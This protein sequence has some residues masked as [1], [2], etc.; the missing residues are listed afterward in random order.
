M[1]HATVSVRYNEYHGIKVQWGGCGY[2]LVQE[3]LGRDC[4]LCKSSISAC[5][6]S[7][8]VAPETDYS[9]D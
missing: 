4:D 8:V 5:F 1:L 2:L 9:E 3:T 6:S 7:T